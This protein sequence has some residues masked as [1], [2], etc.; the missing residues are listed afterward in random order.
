MPANSGLAGDHIESLLAD[1]EGRLWA[2]T[3]TGLNRLRRKSLFA[4]SQGEGLGFGSVQCLAEVSPGVVWAGK[5]SD[6]L[7]RWDGKSFNRLSAAGLSSHDSQITA[8][9]VTHDGICWVATTNSLLLYKDPLAAADEVKMSKP[10]KSDVIALAEDRGGMLWLGTRGGQVWQLRENK[11]LQQ[12]NLSGTNA[13]TAIVATP[14]GSM[15]ISTD[16]NGLYQFK[17][18]S[19][20]HLGKVDGLASEAIRTLYPDAEGA[21]WI[22]TVGD[23]LS[24]WSDGRIA[25]FTPHEGLPEEISEI[26]EDDAGNLWLG[27]S[28]GIA[29]INQTSLSELASG[30]I[31]SVYPR[32]FGRADGMLSEECTGGFCPAGLKTKSGQLWFST[33][34]GVVVINPKAQPANAHVPR[35]MLEEVRVDGVPAP[36]LR[37]ADQDAPSQSEIFQPLRIVPGKHRVEFGY[38]GLNFD[39]PE[40]IRF[41]YRLEGLDTDWVEAGT[42]A[43]RLLQ[44]S[45]AGRIP[46]SHCHLRK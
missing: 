34:K 8:L 13:I 43:H 46:L 24:R 38:T 16:G 4:L 7:Y 45:A 2:G 37:A 25:N 18:G 19:C 10:V 41:R 11:W 21:L 40:L 20:R 6:G 42:L 14:D 5:S 3:D 15:W 29:C 39:A 44:L 27:S 9:L 35:A 23:G 26:L 33:L 17:T 36:L 1:H 28:S 12:T 31:T 30:K 22:G 32:L